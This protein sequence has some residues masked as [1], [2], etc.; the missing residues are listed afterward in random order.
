MFCKDEELPHPYLHTLAKDGL[1]HPNS[2][3]FAKDGL[4][5]PNSRLFA[6]DGL[7]HP[8]IHVHLYARVHFLR[9]QSKSIG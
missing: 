3:S 7:P 5:H 2:R 6:K 8:H 9:F 4:P 1:P